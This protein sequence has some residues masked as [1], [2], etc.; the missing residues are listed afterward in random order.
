[1]L[2]YHNSPKIKID[3]EA[4]KRGC[5]LNLSIL[6]FLLFLKQHDPY[7]NYE[8]LTQAS[9]QIAEENEEKQIR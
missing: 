7:I 1:M 6:Q 4:G 8:Y 2:Y 5:I 3:F 9:L